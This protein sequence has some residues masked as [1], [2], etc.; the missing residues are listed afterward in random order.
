MEILIEKMYL[1]LNENAI[2]EEFLETIETKQKLCFESLIKSFKSQKL[3]KTNTQQLQKN[4]FGYSHKQN[5]DKK[6]T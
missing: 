6:N 3:L 2:V 5:S 4:I 1:F